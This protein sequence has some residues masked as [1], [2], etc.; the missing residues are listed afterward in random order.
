MSWEI[1]L[2][3]LKHLY[4][5]AYMGYWLQSSLKKKS[6]FSSLTPWLKTKQVQKKALSLLLWGLEMITPRKEPTEVE[7]SLSSAV[8]RLCQNVRQKLSEHIPVQLFQ[9][10]CFQ[11]GQNGSISPHENTEYVLKKEQAI[12]F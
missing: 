4:E 5:N 6:L 10:S 8:E 1:K 3:S 9:N 7:R 12:L 11:I 2:P